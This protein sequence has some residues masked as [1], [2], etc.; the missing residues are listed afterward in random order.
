M[1]TKGL[2]F[3]RSILGMHNII[4]TLGMSRVLMSLRS[5]TSYLSGINRLSRLDFYS[6]IVKEKDTLFFSKHNSWLVPSLSV[7]RDHSSRYSSGE[8]MMLMAQGRARVMSHIGWGG[9]QTTIY[10][11]VETFP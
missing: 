8:C 4:A 11:G 3:K 2:S 7:T 10:K 9:E 5:P 1:H 6:R